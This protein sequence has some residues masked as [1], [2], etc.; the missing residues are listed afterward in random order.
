M[1]LYARAEGFPDTPEQSIEWQQVAVAGDS[2]IVAFTPVPSSGQ[3][4]VAAFHDE[5]G[6][7][8]LRRDWVGRPKEG[9]GVSRDAK[10]HFGPPHFEDS[11]FSAT[12]DTCT[13]RIRMRY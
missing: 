9:W 3:Y 13:V 8:A 12:G 6:D 10:A 1:S 5:D 7:G 11:A 2:A 4:A